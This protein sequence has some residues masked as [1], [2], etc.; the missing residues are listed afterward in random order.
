MKNRRPYKRE[1]CATRAKAGGEA[2]LVLVVTR[3]ERELHGTC[4]KEGNII[5]LVDSARR[6]ELLIVRQVQPTEELA[7]SAAKDSASV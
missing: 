1:D 6:G 4:Q 7:E 5:G 2:S 3:S